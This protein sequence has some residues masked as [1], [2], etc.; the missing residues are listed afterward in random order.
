MYSDLKL[1]RE[2]GLHN[3]LDDGERYI[4]NGTYKTNEAITLDDIANRYEILYTKW[5]QVRHEATNRLFKLFH[6]AL[7]DHH[8]SMVFSCMPLLKLCCLES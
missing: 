3:C 5:C 6:M 1:A 8:T 2:C 7:R 4:A